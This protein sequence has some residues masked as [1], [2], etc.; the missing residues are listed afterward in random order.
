MPILMKYIFFVVIQEK[1]IIDPPIKDIHNAHFFGLFWQQIGQAMIFLL[2]YK[3]KIIGLLW[4][5]A[6]NR[7]IF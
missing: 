3:Q 5:D 6:S 4:H 2:L 7:Y 1:N